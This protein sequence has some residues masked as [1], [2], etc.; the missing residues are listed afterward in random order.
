V[1]QT[2]I[3]HRAPESRGRASDDQASICSAAARIKSSTDT[4]V[5]SQGAAIDPTKRL[6]GAS[7]DMATVTTRELVPR[8]ASGRE[9]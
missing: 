6:G 3:K 5:A 1:G 7:S 9:G 8:P 4:I 2:A